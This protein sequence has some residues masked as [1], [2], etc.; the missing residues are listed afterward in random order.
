M[1][2]MKDRIS[3]MKNTLEELNTAKEKIRE[4]EVIA[5]ALSEI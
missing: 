3:M 4:L 1:S 5:I 2:K